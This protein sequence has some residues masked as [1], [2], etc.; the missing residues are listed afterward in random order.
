M[1]K[2]NHDNIF[3]GLPAAKKREVFQIL[4]RGKGFRIE[5][6]VS[7]GQATPQGRWL[8]SK[9]AEWVIVLRGRASLRFQG[10]RKSLDLEAGG[11]VLIPAHARHRVE[12]T[13][14][15][16]KTVWLAVHFKTDP[17]A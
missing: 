8:C 11:H 13:H 5:R 10:S 3:A 16:Q 17:V 9:T 14:P 1:P 7:R 15:R 6:I 12:W 2:I 4:A